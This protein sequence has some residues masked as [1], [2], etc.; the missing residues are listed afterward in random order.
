M[1]HL[2]TTT[3]T[4]STLVELLVGLALMGTTVAALLA[5]GERSTDLFEDGVTHANIEANA[6]RGLERLGRELASARTASLEALPVAPLWQDGISFDRAQSMRAGDGRITWSTCRAELRPEPG[7]AADGLD[8]DGDGLVDEGQLVL[9]LDEGGAEE[10][11]LVLARGVRE[12]LEGELVNGVDDNGNGLV[13]ESG[14]AIAR[15]G[16]DLRLYMTLECLDRHGRIVTRT[17]ET[18]VCTRN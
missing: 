15:S 6:R 13:D 8:G 12:H 3:R 2:R 5:L 16:R 9:V 10:L 11:E 17:L 18:T 4:G 7:E 1:R 14:L